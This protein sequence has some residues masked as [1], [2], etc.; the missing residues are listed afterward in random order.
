MAWHE[1]STSQDRLGKPKYKTRQCPCCTR[2]LQSLGL[3]PPQPA[4]STL[5]SKTHMYRFHK[6]LI[7]SNFE[8]SS[9][10]NTF[11]SQ[12]KQYFITTWIANE[13]RVLHSCVLLTFKPFTFCNGITLNSASI[14]LPEVDII[15]SL[16]IRNFFVT[17]ERKED[18]QYSLFWEATVSTVT[19]SSPATEP[20]TVH[21]FSY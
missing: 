10:V 7:L 21:L 4:V 9:D 3:I 14:L 16:N 20:C 13:V 18:K 19:P 1:T 8:N 17:F 6:L 15:N 2:V 12:K 11:L 5:F